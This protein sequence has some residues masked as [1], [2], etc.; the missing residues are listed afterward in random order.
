MEFDLGTALL[1]EY[2]GDDFPSIQVDLYGDAASPS[3]ELHAPYGLYYRP[4]DPT[5]DKNGQVTAGCRALFAVEGDRHHAWLL[6][7]PRITTI[8]PR[9]KAGESVFYGPTSNFVRNHADGRV[10][11]YT[12]HDGTPKGLTIMRGVDP[13]PLLGGIVDSSPWGSA[14][15]NATGWHVTTLGGANLDMGG[16]GGFPAP[17]SDLVK[18]YATLQ[19]DAITLQGKA[20]SLGAGPAY[21]NVVLATPMAGII[22][23]LE[24]LLAALSTTLKISVVNGKPVDNGDFS[25]A[26]GAFTSAVTPLL[27]AMRARSTAAS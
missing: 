20:V 10:S 5:T 25:T 12:T 15:L 9:L 3:M 2:D 14:K 19:A 22:G 27:I 6:E 1:S 11:M 21:D 8:L 16:I 17:I 4:L 26:L 18:S 13:D 24:T 7:D 23:A